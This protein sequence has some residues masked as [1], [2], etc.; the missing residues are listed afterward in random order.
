MPLPPDEQATILEMHRAAMEV[1]ILGST[2]H[3]IP[4][5]DVLTE[6]AMPGG[7]RRIGWLS[8]WSVTAAVETWHVAWNE[9]TAAT[10]TRE[11]W[12]FVD[13]STD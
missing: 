3:G 9:M 1:R 5:K 12:V 10:V 11:D 4:N 8:V 13:D 6:P 7:W 2:V